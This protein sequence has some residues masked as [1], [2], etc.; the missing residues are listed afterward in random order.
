MP[1][2]IGGLQSLLNI[3][4][5][6]YYHLGKSN[7]E[8]DALSGSHGIRIS[9]QKELRPSSRLLWK[10]PTPRWKFM[11]A[12]RSSLILKSPPAHMT[13]AHWVQEQRVGPTINQVVTWLESNKLDAVNVG[14]EMELKQYLRQQGKLCLW[15]G[16]LYRHSNWARWDC[17]ELQLVVLQEYK[18]EAMFGLHNDIGHLGLKWMLDILQDQFYWPNLDDDAT[19]HIW[20]C[21]CCLRFKGRQDKEELYPLVATYLL[22]LVHM[23]LLMYRKSHAGVNSNI[24]VITDHFIWYGKGVVTPTQTVKATATAFWNEFITN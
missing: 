5:T 6:V 16:V 1:Q 2:D 22:V 24:L 9:K 21:E 17:S 14:E 23:E 20:T 12:M 13:I 7:I 11:P 10:A 4:F 3:N 19:H 15:E 18:I 8:V